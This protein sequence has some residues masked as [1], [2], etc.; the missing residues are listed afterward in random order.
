MGKCKASSAQ[1]IVNRC[2]GDINDVIS[3]IQKNFNDMDFENASAREEMQD[4]IDNMKRH[5]RNLISEL[6]SY[7]FY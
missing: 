4:V 2:I 7:S 5:C 1:Y 3:D 6:H